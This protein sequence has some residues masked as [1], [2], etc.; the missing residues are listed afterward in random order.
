LR[1]GVVAGDTYTVTDANG[2]ALVVSD[3][4]DD[5]TGKVTAIPAEDSPTGSAITVNCASFVPVAGTTYVFQ[6]IKNA[7]VDEPASYTPIADGT[8]LTEGNTYYTSERG[9]GKFVATGSEVAD[10]SEDIYY[11]E[12]DDAGIPGEYQY[13]IIKVAP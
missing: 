6:F 8:T 13:K 9:A 12:C 10:A 7:N 4:T 3:L 11:W 1:Y 2:W 5:L